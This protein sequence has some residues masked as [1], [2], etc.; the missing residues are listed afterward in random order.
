MIEKDL[1]RPWGK[2]FTFVKNQK[3]TLKLL[4]IQP[5]KRLSL[6]SHEKRKEY[7]YVI[8]G[9][10]IAEIGYNLNSTK[11][12]ILNKGQEFKIEKGMIHRLENIGQEEAIVLE[13]SKGWF[14][15]NDI[16]RH[17]DDYERI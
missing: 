13:I 8:H 16:R 6:Q 9:K 1:N 15:E 11:K 4:Y 3:C 5:K 12:F 2:F 7:W 17:Q 10:I 14:D